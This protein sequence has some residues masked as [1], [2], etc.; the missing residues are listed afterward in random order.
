MNPHT[1][2][3]KV[4]LA[5]RDVSFDWTGLPMHYFDSNPFATQFANGMNM[6]LPEGEVFFVDV[7]Q[8]ALP[9]IKDDA[10]R[11]DVI[12]FIGQEATHSSSH[13]SLL[14]YLKTQGLNTDPFV[15][16]VQ[17]LFRRVLGDRDLE[18]R[19]ARS[20]LLERVAIV[21]A[22]EHFTSYLGDWGLNARAWDDALA[23]QVLDLF[24]WHLAEEVEHRHVAFDLFTHLDGG[25]IRRVR[26]WLIASQVLVILW[27]R[28]TRYLMSVDP[29]LADKDR[30]IRLRDIRRAMRKGLIPGPWSLAKMY[31]E[32]F[33]PSYHPSRYGSTSQAVAYL[34]SSPA[35]RAAA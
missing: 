19:K 16:Q 5:A 20:W 13:Q 1:D 21:A 26:T 34:A 33:R 30:R 22:F 14:D 3:D 18:G 7:F 15:A 28:G 25:Y 23:P 8:Q 35:A 27:V 10:V 31:V 6:L 17:W 24:R 29:E 4:A 9:L 32:Y 11:E 2:A 12:G